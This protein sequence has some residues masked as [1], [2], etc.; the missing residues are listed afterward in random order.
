MAGRMSG[1]L[2]VLAALAICSLGVALV[3][4]RQRPAGADA[5]A[6]EPGLKVQCRGHMQA[7]AAGSAMYAGDYDDRYPPAVNWCDLLSPYVKERERYHC[8]ADTA[9]FSY[10]M[11]HKLSRL[12]EERVGDPLRTILLY[13]SG[14][15]RRNECDQ[16]GR[17]GD[18]VPAPPRHEGGNHFA[19]ADGHV[20]WL[21]PE[22]ASLD[23]YRVVKEE[24]YGSGR[25]TEAQETRE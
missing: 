16:R 18:S 24:R 19:F 20:R 17:P 9:E 15:G 12:P 8:P 11:N 2:A 6:D 25:E 23:L 13:E 4:D 1:G 21:A 5:A 22:T 3:L 7:L 10:A 14:S